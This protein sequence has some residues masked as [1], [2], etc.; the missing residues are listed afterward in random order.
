MARYIYKHRRGTT[1][2]WAAASTEI[3]LEGE[4]VI[5]LDDENSLHKLKIGD[6]IHTYAELAYLRAGDE[7]ITQVLAKAMPRVVTVE[8]AETWTQDAE[9]KYSQVIALDNITAYSRLDLQPDANMLAEFKQLGLVFV[10]ENNSGV[11]TVYSVGNMPLKAYTMQATIVETECNEQNAV[12][13]ISVGAPAAQSD[14]AQTDETKADYIKNKPTLAT[15]AAS[16]SYNDLSDKPDIPSID[17]LVTT[18]QLNAKQDELIFDTAPI[19][20]STNPVTSGG[21]YDAITIGGEQDFSSQAVVSQDSS[22]NECYIILPDDYPKSS[23][24]TVSLMRKNSGPT[25]YWN[26]ITITTTPATYTSPYEEVDQYGEGTMSITVYL[27]DDL[28]T[29]N[30]DFTE[31]TYYLYCTSLMAALEDKTVKTKIQEL[32]AEIE[33]LKAQLENNSDESVFPLTTTTLISFFYYDNGNSYLSGKTGY[34]IPKGYNIFCDIIELSAS[35]SGALSVYT[36]THGTTYTQSY[37]GYEYTYYSG[38]TA[39]FIE[40][41][42]SLAG[43]WVKKG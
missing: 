27:S 22:T 1:E 32:E 4:I 12:V 3:P 8:L 7:I 9:G 41:S 35:S 26:D 33:T 24:I 39:D 2:Q 10:T 31:G 29:I 38:D 23:S 13:G 25:V 37:S 6:G 18:E 14:W 20:G 15:V 40:C 30:T 43:C 21:V 17:G 11:I 19:S 16:G 5:E 42:N 34:I 36:M 28:G